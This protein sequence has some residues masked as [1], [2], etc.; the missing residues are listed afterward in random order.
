MLTV[1]ASKKRTILTRPVFRFRWAYCQMED[2]RICRRPSDIKRVLAGL[3]TTLDETYE[4]LLAEMSKHDA[5][6]GLSILGWM[7]FGGRPLTLQEVAEAAVIRPGD[8]PV[9]PDDR[10]FDATEVLRICRSLIS[11][12]SQSVYMYGDRSVRDI[13]IFSHYSIQEY[14]LSGRSEAFSSWSRSA[15]RYIGDCC[16]SSL[17]QLSEPELT[18][19]SVEDNP[20][21][22]YASEHWHTHASKVDDDS[23]KAL[24]LD[25]MHVLFDKDKPIFHNWLRIH[26]PRGYHWYRYEEPAQNFSSPLFYASHLGFYD[27]AVALIEAG[28][29]VNERPEGHATSL[30]VAA[31]AG[32]QEIAKLLLDHGADANAHCSA[33]GTPLEAGAVGGHEQVVRLLLSHGADVNGPSSRMFDS[34][35]QATLEYCRPKEI[36]TKM[37]NILL[38]HGADVTQPGGFYGPALAIACGYGMRE[39]VQRLLAA[40]ADV[41]APGS[42]KY[43]DALQQAANYGHAE[44][45]SWLLER[46]AD[47][48]APGCRRLGSALQG[49]AQSGNLQILNWLAERGADIE[50]LGGFKGSALQAAAQQGH[51]EIVSRLLDLGANINQHGGGQYDAGPALKGASESGHEEV[52]R[53][54]LSRGAD[55]NLVGGQGRDD[56]RGTALQG[57]SSCGHLNVVRLL[58]EA[59]ADVNL[60]GRDYG[61][62]LQAA[63]RSGH[64]EIVGFLLAHGAD[65]NAQG[66]KAEERASDHLWIEERHFKKHGNALQAAAGHGHYQ[67]VQTLIDN[68]ADVNAKNEDFGTVMEVAEKYGDEKIIALLRRH[69]AV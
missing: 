52:V 47:V 23:D 7:V 45:V 26:E 19:Q 66:D 53:L 15:H 49:A 21:L 28:A 42:G 20:I 58:V 9:D 65:V 61:T 57:A 37:A 55:I 29:D 32:K 59:G 17:L 39:V 69:G 33:D 54:L 40:G 63:A 8:G 30:H 50:A 24:L 2:I 64:V 36:A 34:I 1:R 38:D 10:L 11:V 18:A 5:E 6:E 13:M 3:P 12:S 68:G 31:R 60:P 67:I 62:A 27:V 25:Q 35:L 14:L 16:L 41:S 22:S 4:R 46:G 44:I 51:A 43:G 56:D 48:K